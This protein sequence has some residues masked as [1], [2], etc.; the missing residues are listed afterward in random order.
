[1]PRQSTP[2]PSRRFIPAGIVFCLFIFALI[3]AGAPASIRI[4]EFVASNGN[5]LADEDGAFEDWIELYNTGE[6]A[7]LLAGYGL[8]DD[9]GNPYRWVFPEVSVGPGAFLLVW[10][11]GKD[12]GAQGAPLHTNFSISASGE[13]LLLT[14]PDGTRVD[15]TA[16]VRLGRNHAFGRVPDGTGGWFFFDEP[17]PAAPNTTTAYD[18]WLPPPEFSH[19]G[20]RYAEAFDLTVTS[21]AAGAT[22]LYT[23]DGSEPA[24]GGPG[25]HA[26]SI[27]DT[28]PGPGSSAPSSARTAEGTT[29]AYTG[30][31]RVRDNSGDPL[32]FAR[33]STAPDQSHPAGYMPAR[34]TTVARAFVVRART[35]REGALPSEIVTHTYFI[36][37]GPAHGLPTISVVA[38]PARLFAYEHGILVPGRAYDDWW[39]GNPDQ[40]NRSTWQR[41]GNYTGRGIDW[42]VPGHIELFTH[43]GG[44]RSLAQDAG[45]RTHGGASRTYPQKSLRLYARRDYDERNA[46]MSP[47]FA[48]APLDAYGRPVDAYRRLILRIS[49]NDF[50]HSRFRDA[51][52][53]ALLRPMGLD[54]Q[55]SQPAVQY[56]NGEFWGLV[57]IRERIDRHY[58]AA[59]HSLDADDVDLLA[60]RAALLVDDLDE[61]GDAEAAAEADFD[62]LRDFIEEH[63]MS[64]AEAFAAVEEVMDIENFILYNIA[65]IYVDNRDWPHNN[66]RYWR[67]RS[68][69]T[70]PGAPRE[71]DGRWRWILNDLDFGFGLYGGAGNASFNTIAH[72]TNPNPNPGWDGTD[73]SFATVMLR[74][75]LQNRSFRDR[76]INGLFDHMAT[77]FR[78]ART[79]ALID[80]M[81]AEVAAVRDGAHRARWGTL[82]ADNHVHL[83]K[84]FATLRHAAM[85]NIIRSHFTIPP[86]PLA[87]MTFDVSAPG[88]GTLRINTIEVTP[89]TPG[90]PDP[91]AP[92]PF[93][94]RYHPAVPIEITVLP[95]PGYRFSHWLERPEHANATLRISPAAGARVTAVFEP[96]PAPVLLAYW[97]FNDTSALLRPAMTRTGA[98]LAVDAGPA[99]ETTDGGGNGFHGANARGGDITGRH[100]RLNAPLGAAVLLHVPTTG[101]GPPVLRYETRRSGQGAGRQL[102]EYSTDG[103]TFAEFAEIP[104]RE[105]DP[106]LHTFDFAPVPESADNPDFRIRVTFRQGDGGTAGN[107]RIDNLTLDATP[108][109]TEAAA[110]TTRYSAWRWDAFPDP[111]RRSNPAVSGPTAVLQD[112]GLTNLAR[113]AFELGTRPHPGSARLPR[114]EAEDGGLALVYTQDPSKTD[115]ILRP[116]Q[117]ADLHTWS[118]LSAPS[119]P[120]DSTALDPVRIPLDPADALPVFHRVIV[121]PVE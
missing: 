120:E 33:I 86:F 16:P 100:L 102:I 40:R 10:A 46:F 59:R 13:P 34:N 29:L 110:R 62:A 64:D 99:T 42:E 58:L 82:M 18:A 111:V 89:E 91:A 5:V 90:L 47:F 23:L 7:V 77:T 105:E 114:V 48:D 2:A 93:A 74:H 80:A 115:I 12:R 73:R 28:Y 96:A 103:E 24:L 25:A 57:N 106:W 22:L 84:E 61:P 50:N 1:M 55:R 117:S 30:P 94:A 41:P 87:E 121:S 11:S 54:D 15:E 63:D 109:S 36:E 66:N 19:A 32:V 52:I 49:G 37:P 88:G 78:P 107:N 6:D 39:L 112:D 51:F 83:M 65:H 14:H 119:P 60:A 43:G 92:Y 70:R 98:A 97:H 17:T 72:A 44:V 3:Q 8:S 118:P 21:T 85:P 20:G 108:L 27:K 35:V 67:K 101:H 104:V 4:N 45:I 116:E 71:H 56:I 26:Y 31:V 76:F 79:H 68:P 9:P 75:L 81:N 113:Y 38:P 53:H 95:A 69:H